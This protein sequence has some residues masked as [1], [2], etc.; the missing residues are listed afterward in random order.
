MNAKELAQIA[1]WFAEGKE[2]QHYMNSYDKWRAIDYE[3]FKCA[4]FSKLK[5]EHFRLKPAPVKRL[6]RAEELPFP[7]VVGTSQSEWQTISARCGNKIYVYHFGW[8]EINERTTTLRKY[9][10]DPRKP[11]DQWNSFEVE[12]AK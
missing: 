3:D 10:A 12:D 4:D 7:C 9:T 2:V 1:T 8:T 5:F 11:F 6:I